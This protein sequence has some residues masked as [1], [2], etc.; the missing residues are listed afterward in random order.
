[1]KKIQIIRKLIEN[2]ILQNLNFFFFFTKI[3]RNNKISHIILSLSFSI[4]QIR[5]KSFNHTSCVS[6]EH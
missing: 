4:N 2:S 5:I 3:Y 6:I 1:M